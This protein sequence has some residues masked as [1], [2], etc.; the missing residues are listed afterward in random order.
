MSP[1][2]QPGTNVA[3]AIDRCLLPGGLDWGI[4]RDL[5]F[6]EAAGTSRM[7]SVCVVGGPLYHAPT[8]AQQFYSLPASLGSSDLRTFV[9]VATGISAVMP[10]EFPTP[11]IDATGASMIY[12][13]EVPASA[14]A[15][16][17]HVFTQQTARSSAAVS[18]LSVVDRLTHIQQ[19]L[20]LTISHLAQVLRVSRA[21]VYAWQDGRAKPR[22][23]RLAR[24]AELL[25]VADG[26]TRRSEEPVGELLVAPQSAGRSLFDLLT[27]RRWND[28][29]IEEELD[30]CAVA[31]A[32]ER[33]LVRPPVRGRGPNRTVAEDRRAL[34]QEH[35][36]LRL[37]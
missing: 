31:R 12:S 17:V 14:C 37:R 15:S 10:L 21:T 23:R 26:W 2:L 8:G 32:R 5:Q 1:Q 25:R 16:G 24:I 36:R 35:R 22:V 30:L 19:Q 4:G 13:Y 20:S 34:W 7:P 18:P 33:Q 9:T 6:S 28:E 3:P 29:A 27:D 11:F